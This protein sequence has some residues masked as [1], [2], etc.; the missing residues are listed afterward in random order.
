MPSGTLRNGR[1]LIAKDSVLKNKVGLANGVSDVV[2]RLDVDG[3][4]GL[5]TDFRVLN[6]NT[7]YT[8][9][10]VL[11]FVLE[12]P[13][14]FKYIGND[15]GKSMV[16]AFKALMEN[17]SKK[18]SGLDSS[19]K[20]EYVQTNVG[21]NEVFDVFSRTT[22]EKSEPTHTW[23]DVAGRGIS[24]FYETWIVMGMG[25]PITQIPGV[26]TTQ[27]YITETNNRKSAAFNA[28][29]LMPENIAATCIYIEPDPT[30][31]YAVNAWLCTNMMPDNAGDRIGEMDKTSGRETVEVTV[32]FTCIQE[33]NSGTKVLANN[34]LQSLEIRG[35]ASVDRR[36][37]LGDTYEDIVKAGEIKVYDDLASADST[38]I[39]QQNYKMARTEHTT[40]M[41]ANFATDKAQQERS[42]TMGVAAG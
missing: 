15:N 8:R 14:F 22:R 6:A 21:A 20:A 4:N 31:T 19:I 18:I 40:K 38:G 42:T 13:L 25:D 29:S 16:R 34:I 24:L 9:N 17:K 30:C 28:Y 7:P 12:V 10:N 27:K 3:Q 23:D 33:V 11:C 35:M 39:M 37:Y 5:S 32:K 26:V 36:A 2:A 41:K 1:V